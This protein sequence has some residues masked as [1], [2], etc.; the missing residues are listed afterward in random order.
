MSK[1]LISYTLAI[2]FYKNVLKELLISI[3]SHDDCNC[4]LFYSIKNKSFIR[5][6]IKKKKKKKTSSRPRKMN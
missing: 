6:T 4:L 3:K 1:D 2:K 5:G